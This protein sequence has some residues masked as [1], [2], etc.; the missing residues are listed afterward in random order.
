M[1]LADVVIAV[2]VVALAILTTAALWIGLLAVLGEVGMRRCGRCGH[3]TVV[4][5][6]RPEAC[7][8]CRHAK[9]FH[10]AHAWHAG[11]HRLEP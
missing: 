6:N 2:L 5:T 8:Y 9:L 7:V 4:S 1:V 3:L 11:R 10:P